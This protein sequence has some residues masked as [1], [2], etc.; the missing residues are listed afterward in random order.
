M[1]SDVRDLLTRLDKFVGTLDQQRD[2]LVASIQALNRL[3]GTLAGQR[4]VITEALRK[5]PPALDV[6]ISERPRITTALDKLAMFSDTATRLVNDAGADLVK[7]LKNLEPTISALADVGPDLDA[8]AYAPTYPV[9]PERHRPGHQRRL[10]QRVL[11]PRP[12][13]RPASGRALLL[14]THWGRMGAELVPAPGD[15]VP[16]VPV[17]ARSA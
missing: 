14:G 16:A 7:N 8:F 6:L 2:N 4:D 10:R 12:D 17:H 11:H 13:E 1:Q 15:P 3:A 9:H 5:I